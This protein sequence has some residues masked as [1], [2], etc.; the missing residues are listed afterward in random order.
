MSKTLVTCPM[1]KGTLQVPGRRASDPSKRGYD[2]TSQ[3]VPCPNC[4]G[5]TMTGVPTGKVPAD[6]DGNG[7]KHIYK[8]VTRA[9]STV[10][11]CIRCNDTYLIDNGT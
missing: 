5:Q 3:T 4:G 6:S 1:C 11:T 9:T 10:Y 2:A 7:C 8:G